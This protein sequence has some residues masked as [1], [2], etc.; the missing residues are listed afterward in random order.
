MYKVQSDILDISKALGEDTRFAIFRAIAAAEEPLTVKNLV[1]MFG[2]HHSAIRIHL[3]KLEEA[4]LIS[5]RKLHHKGA[6][7]RP[8][9]A[10]VPNPRALSVTLPPRDYQFLAELA[11][12]FAQSEGAGPEEVGEFGQAWGRSFMRSRGRSVHIPLPL[13]EAVKI[14]FEELDSLGTSPQCLPA[15][16]SCTLVIRNCLFSELAERYAPLVCALHQSVM[17]GMLTEII[18]EQFE[19]TQTASIA[20]GE[21]AC[22]AEI[23][24]NHHFR[25]QD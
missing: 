7:G 17:K 6:V 19:W 11:M 5:S 8:Q 23:T 13:T 22:V 18:G 9:L 12:S 3:N 20:E 15:D 1:S 25:P 21:S 4:G 2:M 10:F 16:G 24:T 14:M